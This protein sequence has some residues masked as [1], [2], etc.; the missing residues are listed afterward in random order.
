M[1]FEMETKQTNFNKQH[2]SKVNH[3]QPEETNN[4]NKHKTVTKNLIV[5]KPQ[6]IIN[7]SNNKE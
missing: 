6:F 7:N 3:N 4:T 1:D 5:T 2:G